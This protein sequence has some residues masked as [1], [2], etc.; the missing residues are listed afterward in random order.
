MYQLKLIRKH[1][2]ENDISVGEKDLDA[3]NM[4]YSS[5]SN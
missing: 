2:H 1:K 3:T 5:L 4:C